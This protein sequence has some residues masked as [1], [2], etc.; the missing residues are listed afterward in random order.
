MRGTH[1]GTEAEEGLCI[2]WTGGETDSWEEAVRSGRWRTR[3]QLWDLSPGPT[4]AP[5]RL[6]CL[7]V[8]LF[9]GQ[10]RWLSPLADLVCSLLAKEP[11]LEDV[12]ESVD[13]AKL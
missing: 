11:L 12:V 6:S 3:Q 9:Q 13:G 4:S 5:S 7:S 2:G 1:R 8:L 10:D